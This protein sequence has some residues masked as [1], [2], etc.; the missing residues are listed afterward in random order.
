MRTTSLLF[1]VAA[2][3]MLTSLARADDALLWPKA[4]EL[5]HD[6][7]TVPGTTPDMRVR[8]TGVVS[9]RAHANNPSLAQLFQ[10]APLK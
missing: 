9:P 2:V 4:R 5:Q 3:A 8:N 6:S 10:I 7:R 1:A